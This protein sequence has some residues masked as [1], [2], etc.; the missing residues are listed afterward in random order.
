MVLPII[1]G[2]LALGAGGFGVKKG[3]K[4]SNEHEK[5]TKEVERS[6]NPGLNMLTRKQVSTGFCR[7]GSGRKYLRELPHLL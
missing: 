7:K 1:L 2:A 4:G 3:L 5:S 6:S